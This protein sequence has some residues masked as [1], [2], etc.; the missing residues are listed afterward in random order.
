ME[1]AVDATDIPNEA[2][3]QVED[4]QVALENHTMKDRY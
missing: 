4:L 1:K 2:V 3:G